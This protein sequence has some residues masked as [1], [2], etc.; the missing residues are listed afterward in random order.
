MEKTATFSLCRPGWSAVTRFRLTA[1]SASWVQAILL[2]QPPSSWDY[3]R[4][5]GD[6]S[7]ALFPR[8][9]CSGVILAHCNPRLPGSSDSHASASR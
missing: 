1:I 2:L 9:E 6:Q 8:L 4:L 5:G 7:L 3:R